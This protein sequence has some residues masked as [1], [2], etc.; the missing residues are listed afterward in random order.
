[1]TFAV[2]LSVSKLYELSFWTIEHTSEMSRNVRINLNLR[3]CS[4]AIYGKFY[5]YCFTISNFSG[6]QIV[7]SWSGNYVVHFGSVKIHKHCS[8]W[9][10]FSTGINGKLFSTVCYF[11]SHFCWS[12]NYVSRVSKFHNFFLTCSETVARCIFER[13]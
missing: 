5:L 9:N 4:I 1:M 8:Y 2:T 13:F 6:L 12:V 3:P 10:V 11:L 7:K